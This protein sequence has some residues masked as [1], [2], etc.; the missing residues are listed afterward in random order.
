[1]AGGTSSVTRCAGHLVD[2]GD[3]M[4]EPVRVD[5]D[6]HQFMIS[7]GNWGDEPVQKPAV[8]LFFEPVRTR[9]AVLS[10][11]ASGPVLVECQALTA[12]PAEDTDGWED[13]AEASLEVTSN[14]FTLEVSGWDDEPRPERLDVCGPGVYRVRVHARGRDTANDV[15]VSEPVES[16]LVQAWPAPYEEPRTLKATSERS[17]AELAR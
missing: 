5:V 6:F 15:A 13:V 11:V 10:G 3:H 7:A 4:S 8:C 17:K 16:F 9:S 2:E 12:A 14:L 1:M